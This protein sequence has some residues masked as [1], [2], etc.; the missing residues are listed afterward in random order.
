EDLVFGGWDL[1]PE[2]AYE[3]ARRARVLSAEHLEAVQKPLESIRPMRAVFFKEYV[4]KLR[5]ENVKADNNKQKLAEEVRGDIRS[6]KEQ[7]G[8]DRAVA[9]WCGS[10][11]VHHEA[12]PVHQSL[13][14]FEQGLSKND[15]AISPSMIYAYACLKEKVPYANGAPNLT[16]E[17]PALIEL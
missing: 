5:G 9:I 4:K 6:F 11:E 2:N 12:Q 13:G 3:S 1:F 15:P 10:T 7:H 8:L 17:I 16:L 14:K